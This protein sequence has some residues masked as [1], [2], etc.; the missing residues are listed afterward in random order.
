[1]KLDQK[2]FPAIAS[3]LT[4]GADESKALKNIKALLQDF[5]SLKDP[6]SPDQ[7]GFLIQIGDIVDYHTN[8]RSSQDPSDLDPNKPDWLE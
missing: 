3:I 5:F 6:V 8:K 7:M 2:K 4:A 1:M